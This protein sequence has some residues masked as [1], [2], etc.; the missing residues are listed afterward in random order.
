LTSLLR[1]LRSSI[2]GEVSTSTLESRRRAGGAAYAL[3][4]EA[5]ALEGDDR[6]ARLFRLCAWNAFALQTIADTMLDVDAREHPAS[7]GYVARSTLSYVSACLDAVPSWIR[8]ARIAQSDPSARVAV[9]GSLPK[10]RFDQPTTAVELRCLRSA[11]EAL[12]PRIE[13][14]LNAFAASS[15]PDSATVRRLR[16]LCAEMTSAAD[17]AQGL[18]SRRAGAV[19]RGEI[20]WRLLDALDNAF[21]LGQLLAVPTL[22]EV[23]P[24]AGPRVDRP[25]MA[26]EMT[27]EHIEPLWPV[28]D[29]D[30]VVVGTVA[31]VDGDRSTGELAGIEVDRG[32]D[33]ASLRVPA[34]AVARIGVG[35]VRL[36]VR[37][38]ELR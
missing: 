10:W 30:G 37:R 12:Q 28:R 18:D 14:D 24:L 5:E 36:G 11:Y 15:E 17:Y 21:L 34:S 32:I 6:G 8:A 35:E 13:S 25:P 1:W 26:D 3:F 9:P 22:V 38:A 33:H 7:A 23:T 20:R 4:E 27:W 29:V 2:R 31:R 16:R 19:E